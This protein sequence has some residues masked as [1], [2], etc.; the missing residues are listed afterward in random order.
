MSF[1]RTDLGGFEIPARWNRSRMWLRDHADA[2]GSKA[3]NRRAPSRCLAWA[4]V[5]NVT[6]SHNL[7]IPILDGSAESS[8]TW[9][10]SACVVSPPRAARATL[11]DCISFEQA[12]GEFSVEPAITYESTA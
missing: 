3:L 12:T 10:G 6:R 5:D 7:E 8:R 9:I 11:R 4:N 1:R 2:H